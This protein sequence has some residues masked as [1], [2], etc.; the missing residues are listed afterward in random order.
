MLVEKDT[1]KAAILSGKFG[2]ID[3]VES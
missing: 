2:K 1:L 3:V